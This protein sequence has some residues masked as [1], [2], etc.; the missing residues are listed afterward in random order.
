MSVTDPIADMLTCIRNANRIHRDSVVVPASKV[1]TGIADVLKREGFI[2]DVRPVEDSTQGKLKIY[3][4]YG[5]D[6]ELVL[7]RI[8]RVSKPG[9]RIYAGVEDIK[10]VMR[11]IGLRIVS[12]P[13]GILSDRECRE[14]RVGGEVLCEVW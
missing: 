11:G 3:L 1:K 2:E 12:T 9:R 10:P 6:G 5:E 4:K 14:K 13:A 7:H 8:D